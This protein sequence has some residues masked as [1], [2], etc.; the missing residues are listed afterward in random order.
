MYFVYKARQSFSLVFTLGRRAML[1]RL[2]QSALFRYSDEEH[3]Q[4]LRELQM[5]NET[6]QNEVQRSATEIDN[7]KE[8]ICYLEEYNLQLR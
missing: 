4:E 5:M 2:T 3:V 1:P 7:M 6:L 8:T